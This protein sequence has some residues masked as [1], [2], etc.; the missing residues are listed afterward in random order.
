[1]SGT[2][3][4]IINTPYA[5][6]IGYRQNAF[7]RFLSKNP[8]TK[9]YF[10]ML[11]QVRGMKQLEDAVKPGNYNNLWCA[12][13]SAELVHDIKS[14]DD[15]TASFAREMIEALDRLMQLK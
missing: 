4:T 9:K 14:C 7:E 1:L 12:G 6:K 8:R 15:I 11:V 13:K 5:K 2:P 10:K 3:C